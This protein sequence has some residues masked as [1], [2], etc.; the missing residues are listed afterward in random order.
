MQK[1][2]KILAAFSLIENAN[3]FYW[4]AKYLDKNKFELT[5]IFYNP[6]I[7]QIQ[8][9]I[10]SLGISCYLIKYHGKKNILSAFIKSIWLLLKLKPHIIHT[11]L[12]DASFIMLSVAWLCGYKNRIHTR[13]HS[14][15]HHQYHPQ[16]IKYDKWINKLSK[17]IICPSEQTK[18]ILLEKEHVN[19]NKIR[20]VQH[21]FDFND[22]VVD[23]KKKTAIAQ[24]YNIH[25]FPIIGVVSRFTEWKGVQ[26]IV[27]AFKNF[28]SDYPASLLVFA[29]YKGDYENNIL[30]L[31]KQIPES[32][33]R[34]IEFEK[35]NAALFANFDI[36][37]HVPTSATAETFGQT[38]VEAFTMFIPSIITLSGIAADDKIF[39]EYAE[40]VRYM[41]SDDIFKAL[42]KITQN[43]DE[44]K[45][46]MLIASSIIRN[47]Y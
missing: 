22:F 44:Y 3:E 12:F 41:N 45:K 4:Y 14:D 37:V 18:R 27:P 39:C 5:C 40:V 43:I 26:Y 8:N 15:I 9:E 42:Q 25:G 38:Y 17:L 36:F 7:S 46:K 6:T 31:L 13:H 23:E 35:N 10:S 30:K 33:Y 28:L 2:I 24:K 19:E 34:L 47:K 11:Q 20:V 21:G 1:K 32:N 16:A 29:G